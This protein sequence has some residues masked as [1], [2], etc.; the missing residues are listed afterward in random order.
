[1]K[2]WPLHRPR[3]QAG[4]ARPST[5][6]SVSKSQKRARTEQHGTG[7]LLDPIQTEQNRTEQDYIPGTGHRSQRGTWPNGEAYT[8]SVHELRA[9]VRSP[10]KT[11]P[12]QTERTEQDYIPSTGHHSQ[13][14]TCGQ[15]GKHT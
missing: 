5:Q 9:Q 8:V 3:C 11:N 14:G 7:G 4:G 15:T 6:K 12:I 13:R 1:M 10:G 2:G